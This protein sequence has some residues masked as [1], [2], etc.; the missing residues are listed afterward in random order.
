LCWNHTLALSNRRS[1]HGNGTKSLRKAE[2]E[3]AALDH[4]PHSKRLAYYYDD[5]GTKLQPHQGSPQP[6]GLAAPLSLIAYGMTIERQL[7]DTY[8]VGRRSSGAMMGLCCSHASSSETEQSRT[9]RRVLPPCGYVH[10]AARCSHT[11]RSA[12]ATSI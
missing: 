9:T 7:P 4:M 5:L 3:Q 6:P 10:N 1:E 8:I 11:H 2:A 12:K